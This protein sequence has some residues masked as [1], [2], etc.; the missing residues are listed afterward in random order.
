MDFDAHRDNAERAR[1]LTLAAFQILYRHPQLF[2]VLATSG[3]KA[4]T[5]SFSRTIFT[6]ARRGTACF[7][8]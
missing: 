5:Y 6:I 3:A 7:A 4:G 8:R 1:E 2:V